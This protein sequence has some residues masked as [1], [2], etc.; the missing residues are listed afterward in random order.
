MFFHFHFTKNS[1]INAMFLHDAAVHSCGEIT[2][3]KLTGNF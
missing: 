2:D 3:A 1:S